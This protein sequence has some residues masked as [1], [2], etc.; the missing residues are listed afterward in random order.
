MILLKYEFGNR[1]LS[2][3]DTEAFFSETADS[4]YSD[5]DKIKKKLEFDISLLHLSGGITGQKWEFAVAGFLR[6]PAPKS[7]HGDLSVVNAQP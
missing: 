1:R 7:C 6:L 2:D 3:R 5:L 4:V